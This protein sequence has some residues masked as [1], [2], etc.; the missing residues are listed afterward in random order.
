MSYTII[1]RADT[2][3]TVKPEG[4]LDSAAS[5]ELETELQPHLEG[6]RDILMDF[7]RVEYIS[8]GGL[9]LL[10]ALEQ[11]LED[12]GGGMTV[13]HANKYILEVFDLMGFTDVVHIR[14]E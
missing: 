7:E 11:L 6:I 8:S 9:R 14:Q 3:L 12:R 13:I 5:P 4:R 1:E 2:L 10:L